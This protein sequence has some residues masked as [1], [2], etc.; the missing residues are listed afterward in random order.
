MAPVWAVVVAGGSGARF[1][2]HKQFAQLGDRTVVEWSVQ[3][4]RSRCGG[5]VVVVPP[6]HEGSDFGADVVVAGGTTR[7]ASVRNGLGAV[8]LEAEIVV[9]HD[10]ARPMADVVLFDAVV[11]ALSDPLIAG[12]V[13]GVPVSDTIKRV[14]PRHSGTDVRSIVVE[15]VARGDLIAVQTP[16]AFRAD[17]LRRAHADG[18]IATDDAALVEALGEIV[19]VVP[20]DVRNVKLT[21]QSDLS[22]AE[23]LMNQ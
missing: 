5:V 4:A 17:V 6:G 16:Q 22:Y 1:G 3:A 12:A 18:A 23:H 19:R 11:A 9:I 14:A 15:T 2:T 8:P 20:G 7:S 21:T 10:A 13:C